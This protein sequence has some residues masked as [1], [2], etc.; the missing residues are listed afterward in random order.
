MRITRA[1]NNEYHV[2]E[3]HA[4]NNIS[5]NTEV[6][7]FVCP[8]LFAQ[9]EVKIGPAGQRATGLPMRSG[10]SLGMG[11]VPCHGPKSLFMNQGL[12]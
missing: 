12:C 2:Y 1:K 7:S 5:F 6:W 4:S 3:H 8:L 11:D 9:C 10:D